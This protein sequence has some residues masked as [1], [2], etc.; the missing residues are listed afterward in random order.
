MPELGY[1]LKFALN[2]LNT[3]IRLGVYVVTPIGIIVTSLILGCVVYIIRGF[4]D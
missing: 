3:P 1:V 2:L 4:F